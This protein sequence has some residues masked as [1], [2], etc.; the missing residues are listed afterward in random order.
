V[1]ERGGISRGVLIVALGLFFI[2]GAISLPYWDSL[3]DTFIAVALMTFVGLFILKLINL[4]RFDWAYRIVCG[5]V[6]LLYGAQLIR[7]I[8]H[9]REVP[10]FVSRF[11]SDCWVDSIA[12][13]LVWGVPALD[14]AIAGRLRWFGARTR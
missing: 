8:A 11:R 4:E 14:Y 5:A 3:H 7:T 13:F 6:F 2:G 9:G 10:L 12:G 1:N